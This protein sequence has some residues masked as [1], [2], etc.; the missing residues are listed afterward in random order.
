MTFWEIYVFGA[1]LY[2][3]FAGYHVCNMMPRGPLP[4]NETFVHVVS[5]LITITVGTA[6]WP[7]FLSCNIYHT[8]F[9]K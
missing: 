6:L 1:I 8:V 3:M 9:D 5:G 7:I 4:P 2:C